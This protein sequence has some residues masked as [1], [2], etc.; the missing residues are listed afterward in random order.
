MVPGDFREPSGYAAARSV[1]A[2]DPRPTA[3]FAANDNMAIGLLSA[4]RERGVDVPDDMAVV[5]FDDV[6]HAAT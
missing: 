6:R 2:R 3:V 4:L 1:L 5:G